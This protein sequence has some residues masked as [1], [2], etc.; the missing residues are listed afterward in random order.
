MKKYIVLALLIATIM[1]TAGCVLPEKGP[2]CNPPYIVHGTEC[3]LDT[4]GNGICDKDEVEVGPAVEPPEVAND[5]YEQPEEPEPECVIDSDCDDDDPCTYDS[6]VNGVCSNAQKMGEICEL[7]TDYDAEIRITSIKDR[8]KPEKTYLSNITFTIENTGRLPLTPE[9]DLRIIYWVT[10]ERYNER[11]EAT[12][13]NASATGTLEVGES[14]TVVLPDEI[15]IRGT[16][17]FEVHVSVR[18]QNTEEVI[19]EDEKEAG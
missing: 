6:C 7:K 9:Y 18:Q 8:Y 16:G 1:I 15:E 4:D 11:Y 17:P 12:D 3:C 10:T 19:A 14:A 13:V 2:V 5:T